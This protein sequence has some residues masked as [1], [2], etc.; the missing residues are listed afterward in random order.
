MT[1]AGVSK[2]HIT[3]ELDNLFY[4][5]NSVYNPETE[6]GGGVTFDYWVHT[7]SLTFTNSHRYKLVMGCENSGGSPQYKSRQGYV[8]ATRTNKNGILDSSKVHGMVIGFRDR[9]GAVASASGLEFGVFPTVSQNFND[10]SIGHSIAI[11]E[12]SKGD[13]LGAV[14]LSGTTTQG[15]S[16]TDASSSFIHMS[17]VFNYDKESL[18]MYVDGELLCTSGLNTAFDLRRTGTLN[19][20][21]LTMKDDSTY[22]SSWTPSGNDGPVIGALGL[23]FTPWILGGGF[24]DTIDQKPTLGSYDPGFLGYNTNS[25]YG[26]SGSQHS[27]SLGSVNPVASSA[28]DGFLGSFKV[29][30]KALTTNEVKTNFRGQKGFFKNIKI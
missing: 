25:K 4:P 28:L 24:S 8:E 22:I 14:I 29:Y 11:A 6:K 26:Q 13:E 5:S 7:P 30:S 2:S 27:P 20:P 18:K 15:V 9:G 1:P 10:E 3:Q 12:D 16:I 21:S 17:L 19:I 23:S